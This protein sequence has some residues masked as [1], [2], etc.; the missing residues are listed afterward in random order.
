M[1]VGQAQ[2]VDNMLRTHWTIFEEILLMSS[3]SNVLL[4]EYISC[5]YFKVELS[6]IIVIV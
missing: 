6:K 4:A 2:T 5:C 3:S 1:A